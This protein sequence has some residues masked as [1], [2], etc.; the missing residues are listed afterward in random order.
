MESDTRKKVKRKSRKRK[1]K[2]RV[3]M[4]RTKKVKVAGK[5]K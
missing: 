1:G 5:P 3:W 2:K 4:T